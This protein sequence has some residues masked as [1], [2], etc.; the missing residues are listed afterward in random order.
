MQ[1]FL[2]YPDFKESAKCLDNKR[3]NKQIVEVNQILL[4]NLRFHQGIK[5]GWQSHPA[6]LMWRDYENAICTYYSELLNEWH[7]RGYLSHNSKEN[8][9]YFVSLHAIAFPPWLGNTD[10]HLSHQS[11]LVRKFPEHYRKFF[12]NVPDNLPYVWPVS[13]KED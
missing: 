8:C 10:F 2:P 9:F 4:A 7:R 5:A 3:L 12:P 13:K 6:V 11:N 1:T